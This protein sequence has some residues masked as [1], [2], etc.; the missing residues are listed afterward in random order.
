RLA[1]WK[2]ENPNDDIPR[3]IGMHAFT[4]AG[5]TAQRLVFPY[6]QWL[7]QRA[8]A[9]RHT[10]NERDQ[11]AID[12]LLREIDGDALIDLDIASPVRRENHKLFWA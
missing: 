1:A 11:S 4:M 3:A 10:A 5:S 8:L 7:L 12:A 9:P 6:T 2:R